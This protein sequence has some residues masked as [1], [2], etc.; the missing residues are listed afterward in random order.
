MDVTTRKDC[1]KNYKEETSDAVMITEM[2][3]T[4]SADSSHMTA[5]R[6]DLN[7]VKLKKQ[8]RKLISCLD[9]NK[10]AVAIT[11]IRH[12][13]CGEKSTKSNTNM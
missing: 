12:P 1:F 5:L 13:R 3:A 7:S 8:K 11:H 10:E 4:H 2:I 6:F 9:T